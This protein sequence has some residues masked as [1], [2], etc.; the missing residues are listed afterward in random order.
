MKLMKGLVSVKNHNWR[1]QSNLVDS[2][3]CG[4]CYHE[5]ESGVNRGTWGVGVIQVYILYSATFAMGNASG[6]FLILPKS[7]KSFL[8]ISLPLPLCFRSCP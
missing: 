2:I 3:H 5:R 6:S 8:Y 7:F 4:K 1:R